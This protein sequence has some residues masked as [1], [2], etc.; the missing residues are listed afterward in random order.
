MKGQQVRSIK[1]CG[2]GVQWSLFT[3]FPHPWL[4]VQVGKGRHTRRSHCILLHPGLEFWDMTVLLSF[5]CLRIAL[6]A[7]WHVKFL[8][9]FFLQKK[10]VNSAANLLKVYNKE[11][12][13]DQ[14]AYIAFREK[15]C[16][17]KD[18]SNH[19]SFHYYIKYSLCKQTS[20]KMKLTLSFI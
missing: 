8:T 3:T 10:S 13:S 15:S 12:S 6:L 5:I 4:L 20:E 19:S 9:F 2:A 16:H 17:N 18:R 11:D 1:V 7:D 14:L